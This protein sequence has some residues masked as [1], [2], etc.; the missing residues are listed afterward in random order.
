MSV[1]QTVEGHLALDRFPYRVAL[2]P[3][4]VPELG[5]VVEVHAFGVPEDA[6]LQVSRRLNHLLASLRLDPMP[7]GTAFHRKETPSAMARVPVQA[8][9]FDPSVPMFGLAFS[10][11]EAVS[12]GVLWE[13][14]GG[15]RV[16]M[17]RESSTIYRG[18]SGVEVLEER[19]LW[20]APSAESDSPLPDFALNPHYSLAS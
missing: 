20:A 8:R 9:W 14:V 10:D 13:W 17:V 1:V 2:F 18:G 16:R 3:A 5:D 6:L 15:G 7:I 4:Y 12:S 19:P 11:H